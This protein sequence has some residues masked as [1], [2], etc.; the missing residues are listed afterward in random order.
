V[1]DGYIVFDPPQPILAPETSKTAFDS[2]LESYFL[3]TDHVKIALNILVIRNGRQVILIDAGAGATM[4]DQAGW[5]LPNLEIAGIQADQVTDILLTHAHSDHIGGVITAAG[6]LAFPNAHVY[7][8][9]A[10]HDFWLGGAVN[11][12]KS[13][14]ADKEWFINFSVPIIQAA[15]KALGPRLHLLEPGAGLFDFIQAIPTPGHTAGHTSYLIRSEGEELLHMGDL[16]HHMLLFDH[17]EWGF[18]PDYDFEE[19]IATRIAMLRQLADE[20]MRAFSIHLPWPGL[21]H[22]RKKANAFEWVS[23]PFTGFNA[24]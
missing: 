7:M 11:M 12:S 23:E 6:K 24:G 19:G 20:R 21:G 16:T 4:G 13:K 18:E 14:L 5:L 2:V 10:E 3:P 1:S 15:K 8:S 9:R 22:V 17:P